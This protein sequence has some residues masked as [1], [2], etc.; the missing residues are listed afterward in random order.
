M[1]SRGRTAGLGALLGIAAACALGLF[2]T[3]ASAATVTV[4]SK[5]VFYTAGVGEVNDLSI[6][7]SGGNHLFSDAGALI[8][9]GTGC[10]A[11]GNTARCPIADVNGITVSAGD[12]A[13]SIKNGTS[14]PSTLSGGNGNDTLEGGSGNDKLRGNQGVDTHAGGGGDDYIDSRGD[15]GDLVTCGTGSDTVRADK[16]D[17]I[18]RDCEIV[19]RGGGGTSPPTRTRPPRSRPSPTA[20][21]LLGPGEEP[22]LSAGACVRQ[23]L[24]TT[25]DD[26]LDGTPLG[27]SLF[28]LPGNDGLNGRRGDDCLFGGIGSDRLAGAEGDDRLLG[29]DSKKGVGGDDALSGSDGDDLLSGGSGADRLSGGSGADRL[30][31]DDGSD[32]LKGGRGNDRLVAGRGRNRLVGGPGN[33]YLNGENGRTDRLNCGGGRDSARAD[34]SDRVRGCER[35]RRRG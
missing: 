32:R 23:S 8:G 9:A 1:P 29:D 28:G 21:D 22:S 24:G 17:V 31:G 10:A 27:D 11:L 2:P 30:S 18:A 35:V 3:G 19:D 15:K 12:E 6:F 5:R 13:D 33:D 20:G 4:Q 25:G 34:R 7:T 16:A 26:L 14:A